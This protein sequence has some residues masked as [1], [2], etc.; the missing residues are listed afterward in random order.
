MQT[1]FTLTE[2]SRFASGLSNSWQFAFSDDVYDPASL[3]ATADASDSE[4]PLDDDEDCFYLVSPG[5]SIG[6]TE[7][8]G[9]SVEWLFIASGES[10]DTLPVS[11][12]NRSSGSFCPACG[13]P[14][15]PGSRFCGSCGQKL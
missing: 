10:P 7:D 13:S 2:A 14:V 3:A 6:V 15:E 5:G 12:E 8:A 4:N 9:G 11:L 1:F